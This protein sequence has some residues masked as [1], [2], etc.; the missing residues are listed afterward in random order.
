MY[1][2]AWRIIDLQPTINVAIYIVEC[3]VEPVV[4]VD[5]TLQP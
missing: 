4:L 1:S 5:Y 3:I 2:Y